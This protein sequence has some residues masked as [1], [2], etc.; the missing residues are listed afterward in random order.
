MLLVGI[1][2]PFIG[3][4][5]PVVPQRAEVRNVREPTCT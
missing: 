2:I 3:I 5:A 4:T 1:G